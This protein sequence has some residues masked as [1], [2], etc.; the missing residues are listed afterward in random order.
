M[1][2]IITRLAN[3]PFLNEPIWRWFVFAIAFGALMAGWNGVLA[4]MK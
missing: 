3:W 2:A 1:D 4:F